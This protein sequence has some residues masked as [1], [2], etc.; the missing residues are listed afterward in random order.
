MKIIFGMR[1]FR[2]AWIALY[3]YVLAFED[4]AYQDKANDLLHEFFNKNQEPH[5]TQIYEERYNSDNEQQVQHDSLLGLDVLA[6]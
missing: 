2:L 1:S 3:N 5:K 6:F 4:E